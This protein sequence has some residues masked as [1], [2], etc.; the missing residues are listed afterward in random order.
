M[1]DT[2][3]FTPLEQATSEELTELITEFE[4][5]RERLVNET[6]STAQ[7]AKV[8]KSQVMASLELQLTQ[9]DAQ[10]QALRQ[11]QTDLIEGNS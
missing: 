1:A 9:I 2:Q 7:R 10:L 4:Q 6:L 3:E 8:M 11:R 5:Y